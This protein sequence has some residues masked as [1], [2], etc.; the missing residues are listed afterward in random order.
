MKISSLFFILC[1]SV[2][3]ASNASEDGEINASKKESSLK[4][5][6]EKRKSNKD[7]RKLVRIN[8]AITGINGTL[9]KNKRAIENLTIWSNRDGHD[10][11]ILEEAIDCQ[12]QDIRQ[13]FNIIEHRDEKFKSFQTEIERL[14]A[15]FKNL[16]NPENLKRKRDDQDDDDNE[17]NNKKKKLK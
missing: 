6:D 13:L 12:G 9:K 4:T 14:K 5:I 11:K 3:Y 10:I 1:T 15:L 8:E 2:C 17:P 16:Q 7:K